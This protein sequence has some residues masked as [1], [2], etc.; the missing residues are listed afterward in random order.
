MAKVKAAG[1][2]T[3]W[4]AHAGGKG[5]MGVSLESRNHSGEALS[6]IVDWVNAHGRFDEILVG[7]SDT[8]NRH[9][10]MRDKGLS[11]RDAYDHAACQGDAWL[12]ANRPIL[13]GFGAPHRV[14][15]WSHWLENHA[16]AVRENRSRFLEAHGSDLAFRAS[17]D[18][19]IAA[20]VKRKGVS[21]D[22]EVIASCRNY[23][24]EELAVYSVILKE[25]P[26]TVFYPGK[27]LNCFA[28][29]REHQPAHL[30]RAISKTGFIRLAVHGLCN[31]EHYAP[32][33]QVA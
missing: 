27:Q 19:D 30:P 18:A 12:E 7:L 17:V 11:L 9:N 32:K 6:A 20:F 13:D 2:K 3:K 10:Y 15:R 5:Y 26:A 21:N 4:Q 33:R 1:A 31:G 14:V 23:L 24:I 8:L 28:Y 29:L 22:Q 16:E 25:N